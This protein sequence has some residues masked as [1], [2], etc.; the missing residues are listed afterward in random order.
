[1]LLLV[2]LLAALNAL[3]HKLRSP[4]NQSISSKKSQTWLF[5]LHI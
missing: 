4:F 3:S 2:L 1:M 5:D